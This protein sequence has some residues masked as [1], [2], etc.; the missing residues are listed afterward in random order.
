MKVAAN[1]HPTGRALHAAGRRH[2]P[3]GQQV[4]AAG[5]TTIEGDGIGVEHQ[6]G[7]GA[8]RDLCEFLVGAHNDATSVS[9]NMLMT[10]LTHACRL[11]SG[12]IGIVKPGSPRIVVA[13][14]SALLHRIGPGR[15]R[16]PCRANRRRTLERQRQLH[17][18]LVVEVADRHAE[19]RDA[20]LFDEAPVGVEQRE[21]R[22]VITAVDAVA[23]AKRIGPGRPTEV[24]EPEPQ[25]DGSADP[26]RLAHPTRDPIDHPPQHDVDLVA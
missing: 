5:L 4:G 21:R 17:R 3:L 23:S 14:R 18:V 22:G 19:Q 13:R 25:R 26:T 20:A 9:S 2:V 15:S 24:V 16:R 10:S 1:D 7:I 11:Q 12:S 8:Q 6:V